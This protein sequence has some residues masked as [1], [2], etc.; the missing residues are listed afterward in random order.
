MSVLLTGDDAAVSVRI[1]NEGAPIS[2]AAQKSLFIPLRQA[3]GERPAG[4]SGLSL[5]LYI[6]REIA[7]AHGGS[8][9]VSSDENV[10]TFCVRLP[11]TLPRVS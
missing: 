8:I 2:A 9:E 7:V 11:R 4:S 6:S 3:A 5:G 1:E 10:T